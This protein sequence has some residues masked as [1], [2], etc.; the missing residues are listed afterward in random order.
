LTDLELLKGVLAELQR[1]RQMQIEAM[2]LVAE[3]EKSLS[4]S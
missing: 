1:E 3:W 4:K 2:H